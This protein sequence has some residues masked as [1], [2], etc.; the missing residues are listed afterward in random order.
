GRE[1]DL[2]GLVK[3]EEPGNW[4]IALREPLVQC[5]MP[6][7]MVADPVLAAAHSVHWHRTIC[8]VGNN[9]QLLELQ[10]ERKLRV[11]KIEVS[12]PSSHPLANIGGDGSEPFVHAFVA[13]FFFQYR[14]L[15]T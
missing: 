4:T 3:E 15:R 7:E 14:A 10:P 8:G 13:E 9:C 12:S 6:D 2:R 11:L 5:K 1:V